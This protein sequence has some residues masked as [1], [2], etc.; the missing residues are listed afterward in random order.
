MPLTS[1]GSLAYA[2]DDNRHFLG[3]KTLGMGAGEGREGGEEEDQGS[4]CCHVLE[5]DKEVCIMSSFTFT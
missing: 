5:C 4:Y 3:I 1:V 2:E